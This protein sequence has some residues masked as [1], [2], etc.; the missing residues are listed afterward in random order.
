MNPSTWIKLDRNILRWRWYKDANTFR[1]F[2]H[3]LLNA[4]IEDC[5]FMNITV[6]RGEIATSH[7]KI[8]ESLGISI[9]NTRT[10]LKHLEST[11]ELTVTRYPK[12]IVISIVNYDVYQKANRQLTGNLQSTNNQLTTI[13]EYKNK[14]IKEKN[15]RSIFVAENNATSKPYHIPT[16][17]EVREY[18]RISSKGKD[19]DVF[20]EH[21]ESVNWM[22]NNKPIYDWKSLYE[23]WEAPPKNKPA[24]TA[25][26]RPTRFTDADGIT[27]ELI[28]GQYERVR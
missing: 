5:D 7:G 21:Y 20:F 15:Y 12:F 16:L 4:N 18:E 19:P 2:I 14:R 28:N 27:Y 13:K 3:L 9:Q 22:A 11:Q 24:K 17:D 25:A 8:A 10:A 23:V 6:H 26:S 1:V